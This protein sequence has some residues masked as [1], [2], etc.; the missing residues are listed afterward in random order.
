MIIFIVLEL[1]NI[2][3]ILIHART[4]LQVQGQTRDS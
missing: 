2:S 3:H 4:E 1:K